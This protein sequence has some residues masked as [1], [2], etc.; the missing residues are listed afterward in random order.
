MADL[1]TEAF[2]ILEALNTEQ[3]TLGEAWRRLDKVLNNVK[4]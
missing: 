2:L 3:I 4:P 1:Q